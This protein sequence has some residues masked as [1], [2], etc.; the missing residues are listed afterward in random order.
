[1]LRQGRNIVKVGI[2]KE[3]LAFQTR[4]ALE[5]ITRGKFKAVPH[6]VRGMKVAKGVGVARN[7]LAVFT[8]E[9]MA[10]SCDGNGQNRI[11][12]RR[13]MEMWILRLFLKRLWIR[14]PTRVNS[15]AP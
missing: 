12:T 9:Y 3:A 14:T 8:R 6:F 5:R 4:E 10:V 13:W 11:F 2:P 15:F 1:M 7:T